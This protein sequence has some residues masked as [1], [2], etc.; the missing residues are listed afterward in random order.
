[1]KTKLLRAKVVTRV[2]LWGL[3]ALMAVLSVP[4]YP[5]FYKE[6][7]VHSVN[8]FVVNGMIVWFFFTVIVMGFLFATRILPI[9]RKYLIKFPI[10]SFVELTVFVGYIGFCDMIHGI[11]QTILFPVIPLLFLV[12]MAYLPIKEKYQEASDSFKAD[13]YDGIWGYVKAELLKTK[14]EA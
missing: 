6:S 3:I 2:F 7:E 1:M 8:E 12:G 11:W 4:G 10:A 14:K 5:H 9:T 13:G